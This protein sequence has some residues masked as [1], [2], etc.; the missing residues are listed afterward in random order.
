MKKL[1]FM[2]AIVSI[3]S[4]P[5]SNAFAAG[6]VSVGV[7]GGF[8]NTEID[9]FDN[10]WVMGVFADFGLPM[11][12]WSV[13]PFLN[14]WSWSDEAGIGTESADMTFSDWTIGGNVKMAIPTAS[15]VRPFIGAGVSA[16]VLTA[17][18]DMGSFGTADA[19][20][21][22]LGFQVGGGTYIDAGESWSIVAQSWY[23][24]VEDFNQWSIRG[25][26]AWSL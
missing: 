16:H 9:E 5:F 24:M 10:T 17:E 21:T 7:E 6:P 14:Y 18:L 3:A 12:N 15:M 8:V 4:L 2:I 1:L 25:G 13:E 11:L 23:H 26:I 19:S 22:K 20:D